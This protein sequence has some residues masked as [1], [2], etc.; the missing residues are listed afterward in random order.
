MESMGLLNVTSFLRYDTAHFTEKKVT[1]ET[2]H[3]Y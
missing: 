1:F 2:L 3:D